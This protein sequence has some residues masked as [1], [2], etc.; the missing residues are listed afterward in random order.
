MK[1]LIGLLALCPLLAGQTQLERQALEENFARMDENDND[2]LE[3]SEFPGSDRQFAQMDQDRNRKVTLEEYSSSAVGRRFLA[4]TYRN[5]LEPRRRTTTFELQARRLMW[6]A[7]FDGNNDGKL[8]RGEWSGSPQA[9]TTLDADGNDIIDGRDRVE[10]ELG[11]PAAE[12]EFPTFTNRLPDAEYLMRRLDRNKD[13]GL[14]RREVGNQPLG[15]V[16]E[17]ADLDRDEQLNMDELRRIV[18]RVAQAVAERNRGYARPRAYTVPFSTW[19]KNKD[20]RLEQNEW[21][22]RR[23]LFPRIDQNRDAAVTPDEVER[24]RRAVEGL[25]FLER[26]DLNDDRRVTLEEFG[27]SAEAFRRADRNGD[28]VVSR[29]DR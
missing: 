27:G 16:F 17:F 20:G 13:M 12:P 10:A 4:A 7:R 19:D 23:N 1:A 5:S 24:Y 26:F 25:D 11:Q 28:G 29:R 18:G 14:T 2:Q 21:L 6:I 15:P 8:T 3:R 22:A 9:F